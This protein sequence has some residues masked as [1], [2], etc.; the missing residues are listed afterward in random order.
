MPLR[1]RE[2]PRMWGGGM[3]PKDRGPQDAEKWGDLS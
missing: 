2:G 3:S 1:I